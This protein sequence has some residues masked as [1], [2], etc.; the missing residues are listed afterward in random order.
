MFLSNSCLISRGLLLYRVGEIASS[1]ACDNAFLNSPCFYFFCS[2]FAPRCRHAVRLR[3]SEALH[4]AR[5]TYAHHVLSGVV[6][7]PMFCEA[8]LGIAS[9]RR[10]Q[11]ARGHCENRKYFFPL[12]PACPDFFVGGG[13][14]AKDAFQ[15][16]AFKRNRK[17]RQKQRGRRGNAAGIQEP[18]KNPELRNGMPMRLSDEPP[19]KRP[20]GWCGDGA[21]RPYF[22]HS[23]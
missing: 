15:H 13:S 20:H 17:K 19:K 14:D 18:G 10:P 7:L 22:I 8:C 1:H 5:S 2:P 11:G 3:F 4:N 12:A 23:Y 6:G 21:R 9:A 16:A